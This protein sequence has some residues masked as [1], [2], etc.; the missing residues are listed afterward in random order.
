MQASTEAPSQSTGSK[1]IADMAAV[2][3]S[4]MRTWSPCATSATA[5]GTT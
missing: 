4:V 5:R 1:T 3:P 2:R